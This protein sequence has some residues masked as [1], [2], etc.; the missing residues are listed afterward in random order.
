MKIKAV[1]SNRWVSLLRQ[2]VT[3]WMED[4][5]LKLSAAMAYYSVFSIAPLL[6]ICIS[7]A[8]LVLGPDAVR[9]HLDDQLSGYIGKKAAEGV[10]SM[11]Q[12]A[13]KPTQGWIGTIA[14]FVVLLVGASGVFG[15]LQD[16]LNTIWDVKVTRRTGVAGFLRERLLSFGMVLA[17][18]F[19]LLV[20]LLLSAAIAA[21]SK[22][23]NSY[24]GVPAEA[25]T[26]AALLVSMALMTVLFATIFKVL[27]DIQVRWGEVWLGAAVTSVL[28]E[29]GKFG[30]GFYLGRES[31]A[32]TY[33]AAASVV[34]LLLWVYYASCILLLG[35]EF[36]QVHARASGRHIAPAPNAELISE[37]SSG[38]RPRTIDGELVA[39]ERAC[40]HTYSTFCV[41]PKV[42]P[43]AHEPNN[44]LA[45]VG[46][47]LGTMAV[48]FAVGLTL[49]RILEPDW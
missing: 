37:E 14:G 2:T 1:M 10:Q 4:G 41:E 20:S 16:A 3:E 11:V 35:A 26:L 32:S 43:P 47:F 13:A 49:R 27:P 12:S 39:P 42:N 29:I 34:L 21:L 18:G 48:S 44:A 8:G 15:Q 36:T 30:L 19:L 31:T 23:L 7:L 33:G 6:V 45:P 17:I 28:F 46:A 25:W 5:A 24:L 40:G 22:Y 38:K 9:G